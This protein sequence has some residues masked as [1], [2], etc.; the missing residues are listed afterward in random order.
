MAYANR[1]SP[2]N[3]QAA[4][5]PQPAAAASSM[6]SSAASFL[7]TAVSSLST[8]V[9]SRYAGGPAAPTGPSFDRDLDRLYH[10]RIRPL[11]DAVDTL[12]GVLREETGI[13]LP[14]IVVVGDQS[15][16]QCWSRGGQADAV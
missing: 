4:P 7:G 1:N 9:A 2:A 8:S 11:L 6:L 5:P 12:R 3:A 14:T 13:Q 15:S 10:V 16:G